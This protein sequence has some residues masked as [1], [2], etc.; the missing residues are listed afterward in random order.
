MKTRTTRCLISLG[1]SGVLTGGLLYYGFQQ[2]SSGPT[3]FTYCVWPFFMIGV[4]LSGNFH[5]S[6]ELATFGSMFLFFFGAA[7][8]AQTIWAKIAKNYED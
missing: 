3:F 6:S 2:P 7:Y 4:F 1:V 5:R 8:A